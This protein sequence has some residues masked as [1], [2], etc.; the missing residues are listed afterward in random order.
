MQAST[1]FTRIFLGLGAVL[2][3]IGGVAFVE[4]LVFVGSAETGRGTITTVNVV[5]NPIT[6]SDTETGKHYYPEIEY[7]DRLT[8]ETRTFSSPAGLTGVNYAEGSQVS[9]LYVPGQPESA[10]LDTVPGI[11]GFALVFGGLGLL[12]IIFSAVA[13]RGFDKKDYN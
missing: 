11:Y 9:V 13:Y 7:V 1:L 3:L 2:L 5:S 4:R 6:Q 10:V 12:F 8:G